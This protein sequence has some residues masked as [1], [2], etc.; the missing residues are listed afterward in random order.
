MTPCQSSHAIL[1]KNE[2]SLF[3]VEL[4]KKLIL[5]ELSQLP[6]EWIF[7]YF[8]EILIRHRQVRVQNAGRHRLTAFM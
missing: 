5:S 3:Y 6:H 8:M 1:E 7:D 4:K 2:L